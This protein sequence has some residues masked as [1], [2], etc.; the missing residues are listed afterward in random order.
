VDAKR[1]HRFVAGKT[2]MEK[3]RRMLEAILQALHACAD[4]VFEGRRGDR[5]DDAQ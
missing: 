1:D 3:S 4:A 5:S 2:C